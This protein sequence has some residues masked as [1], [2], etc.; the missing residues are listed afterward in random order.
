MGKHKGI[1]VKYLQTL[2]FLLLMLVSYKSGGPALAMIFFML[3]VTITAIYLSG[4]SLS[5][6]FSRR[7]NAQTLDELMQL[8]PYEFEK[9]IAQLFRDY[10]YTVHQTR[11]S[12]DGGKDLVMYKGGETYFVECKKY[13]KSNKIGRP[14]IQKLVGACHPASAKPIFVTTSSFTSEAISEA[15][16]SKVQLIDGRG[17]ER[18][19]NSTFKKQLMGVDIVSRLPG[20]RVR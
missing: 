3:F 14:L 2:L 8:N 1:S 9:A 7:I 20:S 17:L 12:A 19:L 6:L 16:R 10:G 15:Q 4:E 13:A 18:M 5:G 11:K